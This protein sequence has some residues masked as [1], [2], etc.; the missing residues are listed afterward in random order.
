LAFDA[1]HRALV[2]AALL[3]CGS[4]AGAECRLALA[5]GF[6][7]SRSV[8]A[9]DYAIQHDGIVEALL[10]P[11]IRDAFLRPDD[12]VALAIFEW[13]G[14]EHQSLILDWTVIG[15]GADLAFAIDTMR[16]H[17]RDADTT[18]TG[19]GAAL[20][21]AHDLLLR[22][23]D[24]LTATLDISG[25]GQNNVGASP[26]AVY[27]DRDFGATIVNGLAIGGHESDIVRYYERVVIRGRGAF[28]EP[29]LRHTD[30]PRAFRRK[31]ERELTEQAVSRL[32]AQERVE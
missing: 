30:F 3:A 32:G 16:R 24:C 28:V 9:T 31:L 2:A 13:S 6:D 29:A 8:D 14:A 22:A 19:L 25:D 17:D 11:V 7:V 15:N 1:E 18:A 4:P 10:D 26:E 20:E 27:A 5:L 12:P 23:P 21:Y